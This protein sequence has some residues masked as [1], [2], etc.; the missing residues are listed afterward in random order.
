MDI[1]RTGYLI[2]NVL[3]GL[4]KFVPIFVYSAK[5][6]IQIWDFYLKHSNYNIEII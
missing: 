2:T 5:E 6:N 3:S 4:D 1:P